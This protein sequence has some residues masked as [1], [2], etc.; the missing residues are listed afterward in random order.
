M[1]EID[2]VDGR[3]I[4][5]DDPGDSGKEVDPAIGLLADRDV[6]AADPLGQ[7]LG[8]LGLGDVAGCKASN[9]DL[10]DLCVDEVGERIAGQDTALVQDSAWQSQRMREDCSLRIANSNTLEFHALASG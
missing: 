10:I 5:R 6:V 4:H 3:A 7:P 1:G 9:G 8:G 2:A